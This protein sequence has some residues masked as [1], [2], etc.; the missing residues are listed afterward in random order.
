MDLQINNQI[1]VEIQWATTIAR[2]ETMDSKIS[3]NIYFFIINNQKNF[4]TV[5]LSNKVH[6][7]KNNWT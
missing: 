4:N 2:I 7:N 6:I 3:S 5:F 1:F